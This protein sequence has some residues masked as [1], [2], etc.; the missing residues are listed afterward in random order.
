MGI[1]PLT[2]FLDEFHRAL[3]TIGGVVEKYNNLLVAQATVASS[4]PMPQFDAVAAFL[5]PW[6]SDRD[7]VER[8]VAES[9]QDNADPQ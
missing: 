8:I 6:V 5:V 7:A 9:R 4:E 3:A 1:E 2:V